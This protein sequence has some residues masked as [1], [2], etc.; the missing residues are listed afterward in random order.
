MLDKVHPN[1]L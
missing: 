1:Y